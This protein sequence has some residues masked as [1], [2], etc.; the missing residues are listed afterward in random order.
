MK[1]FCSVYYIHYH[2]L[3]YLMK[4]E[5]VDNTT[6]TRHKGKKWKEKVTYKACKWRN[7]VWVG[8]SKKAKG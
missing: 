3:G 1:A 5:G 7:S 8:G 6:L 4:K 2:I